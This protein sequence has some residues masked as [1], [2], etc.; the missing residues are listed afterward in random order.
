MD[1][2]EMRARQAPLKEL[3][4]S[5]PAKA[6]VEIG[7]TAAFVEDGVNV[8]VDTALGPV[9]AGQHPAVGG[10]PDDK[11]SAEMLL[12]ALLGCAGTTIRAVALAMRIDIRGGTL[13]AE[14]NFD[15]RGTLGVDKSVPV[16]MGQAV[17]TVEIDTDAEDDRLARLAELSERYCI[18]A[19]T[20]AIAPKIVITR[21]AAS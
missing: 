6:Y 4:L 13:R 10:T 14:G 2:A 20:L 21:A 1:I 8:T 3:Y 17:V 15:A 12:E 9:R 16:G 11:C 5:D 19:Q 18:V 7:A